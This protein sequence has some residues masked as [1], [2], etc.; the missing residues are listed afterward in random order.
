VFNNSVIGDILKYEV[1]YSGFG[2]IELNIN[3]SSRRLTAAYFYYRNTVTWAE[4]K[5]KLGKNYKKQKLANGRP[6]FIYQFGNRQFCVI[7][8][9][10]ENVYNVGV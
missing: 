6:G 8:D 5:Q 7:V 1:P 2:T 9:S 4:V 10:A 3:L